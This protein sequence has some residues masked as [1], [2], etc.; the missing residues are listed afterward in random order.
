[1]KKLITIT[2][3]LTLFISVKAQVI[4]TGKVLLENQTSHDSVLVTLEMTSPNTTSYTGY[5]DANGDYA[6]TVAPGLFNIMFTKNEFFSEIFYNET[7]VTSTTLPNDTLLEHTTIINI[8]TQFNTIQEGVNHAYIGDTLLVQP[9]TYV[10][11]IDFIG[12]DIVVASLYL[13]TNDTSY[14]AQTIIDGNKNGTADT[15]LPY[16]DKSVV[17]FNTGETSLAQLIGF[18][19]QNGRGVSVNGGI[20]FRGGG[21]H[22]SGASPQLKYLIITNNSGQE[23]GAGIYVE[24][25][26]SYFSNLQIIY[27]TVSYGSAI[28]GGGIHIYQSNITIDSSLIN[29]NNALYGAGIFISGAGSL[30]I[31]NSTISNNS[32]S[33]WEGAGIYYFG[34]GGTCKNVLFSENNVSG[35]GNSGYGSGFGVYNSNPI[36]EQCTFID[37]NGACGYI[38]GGSNPIIR[39]C[40]FYDNPDGAIKFNGATADITYNNFFNNGASTFINLTNPLLLFNGFLNNIGD[41]CD[42][43]Y[44]IQVD[45]LFVNTANQDYHLQLSSPCIDAGDPISNTDPDGTIADM[46]CYPYFQVISGCIDSFACNYDA[47]A[48]TNDGSCLYPTASI[49]SVGVFCDTY[50]WIDGVT[51]TASNNT[52]TH[53]VTNAVGCDSTVTLDLTITN[54]TTSTVTQV[55]CDS[56][57]WSVN[58]LTYTASVNDTVIGVNAAG[59]TETN[60]LDLTVTGNPIS[61]I[62]QNGIDLEATISDAYIWNTSATTQT[63]T[64]TVNGWYWCVVTDANGC[65]ADTAFYEVTN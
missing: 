58:G 43:Y 7:I 35:V 56:Y 47:N 11:N 20:Y 50:T 52:A 17:Q 31:F 34:S 41:S 62:T 21:I 33:S 22:I 40:I 36:F 27:N 39:N 65:I 63:I 3:L 64:P 26:S 29:S 9:G 25:S 15:T 48:N 32:N 46:G 59:C 49:A 5:T 37:N 45:P 2:L 13:T 42:I 53:T 6:I 44:N 24:S 60:I 18:T 54:S 23:K 61:T 28:S 16:F 8:P 51:Y 55:A 14:I 38:H 10:E 57:I 19:V 12:K 4:V 1:M 30:N